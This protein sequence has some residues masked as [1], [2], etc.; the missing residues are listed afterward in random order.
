MLITAKRM[1]IGRL[2]ICQNGARKIQNLRVNTL[3]KMAEKVP[4]KDGEK[5]ATVYNLQVSGT[6]E[7]FANNILVHNCMALAITLQAREQQDSTIVPDRIK[8]E[9]FY[10]MA[11]LNAMEKVG[12]ITRSDIREYEKTNHVIGM[13]K[14]FGTQPQGRRSRYVREK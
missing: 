11:E 3:K 1:L 5:T 2:P 9:G 4:L 7:Y 13:K 14:Q 8:P 12:K 10:F 6:H